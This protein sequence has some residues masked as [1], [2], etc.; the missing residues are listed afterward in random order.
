MKSAPRDG[1]EI[2][3]KVRGRGWVR[4]Y[5]LDCQW[6][7]EPGD[8]DDGDPTIR[9]CWRMPSGHDVELQSARGWRPASVETTD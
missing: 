9:D 7:R 8:Y 6:L 5:Y 1:S 2:E 4:A 3:I